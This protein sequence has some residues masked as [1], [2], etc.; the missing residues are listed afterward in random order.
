MGSE[1]SPPERVTS[2]KCTSLHGL[3]RI[4]ACGL[5]LGLL[6][7]GCSRDEGSSVAQAPSMGGPLQA[8]ERGV[9][10]PN[11]AP[12]IESIEFVPARPTPGRTVRARARVNDPDGDATKVSFVWRNASG[13][14][15]G[16]GKSFDT[17][18]LEEGER[19]EVVATASDGLSESSEFVKNFRLAESSVEIGLVVID[20]AE[21][22]QP[23]AL[24]S[25]VVEST[26]E[27]RGGYDVVYDWT[28]NG[29]SVGNDDELATSSFSPGDSV[30]LKAQFEYRGGDKSRFV[31]S[32]PVVLTRGAAPEIVSQPLSGI[33]GGVFRYTI[34]A[35]SSEP[36]AQLRYEL[37]SGPDGMTVGE[38]SGLVSWRP[39]RAQ[40]GSFEV[41]VA[42][43]DQW[44]SGSAQSFE[45]SVEIPPTAPASLR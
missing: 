12:E 20:D 37:L 31:S 36:A 34:R 40:T 15:L 23:G 18:G 33:E 14:V 32:Q 42:A 17:Q 30:V 9:G 4:G 6:T 16:E 44:G 11:S 2:T 10:A 25:A 41:E 35:K 28:V 13:R 43:M 7:V 29:E 8:D 39:E 21:G 45:I 38:E 22:R 5:L 27:S 24:L 1:F 3:W 26:D 19:V